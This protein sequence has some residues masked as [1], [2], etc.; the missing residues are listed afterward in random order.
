MSSIFT[1][2]NVNVL[3]PV[4]SLISYCG[5][6]SPGGWLL[7]DGTAISRITYLNLYNIIGTNFGSGDGINTFNLPD[8]RSKFLYGSSSTNTIGVSGGNSNVTLTSD[9]L[10]SHTHTASLSGTT[11]SSS[12]TGITDSGHSHGGTFY[13]LQTHVGTPDNGQVVITSYDYS[14]STLTSY[15]SINDPGHSHDFNS[16]SVSIGSTGNGN[17]FSI[18]PS[19]ITINYIIKI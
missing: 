15:A 9:N 16:A 19:Y 14:K 17:A 3:P 11:T 2:N 8:L 13:V 7:C 1:Y 6:T 5:I 18:L 12:T 10:P 4:G